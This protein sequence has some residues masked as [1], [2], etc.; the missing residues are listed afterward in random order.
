MRRHTITFLLV[1]LMFSFTTNGMKV[2]V[3]KEIK[4]PKNMTVDA[5]QLYIAEN[6]TVYIYSLEDFKLIKSFGRK[7]Q[8][9]QEF[10]TYPHIPIAIDVSTEKLIVS[11]RIRTYYY[12]RDSRWHN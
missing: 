10:Q 2:T 4:Q 7:G 1:L 12:K 11:T 3:L 8:G 5:T 9:P 6:A